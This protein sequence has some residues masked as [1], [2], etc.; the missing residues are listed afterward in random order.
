MFSEA[1]YKW[2]GSIK[3]LRQTMLDMAGRDNISSKGVW[4]EMEIL[5]IF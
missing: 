4:M 2:R 5:F 1:K 3:I